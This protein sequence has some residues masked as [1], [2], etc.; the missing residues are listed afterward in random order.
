MRYTV[1]LAELG[2]AIDHVAR[3]MVARRGAA[4]RQL[5]R[6][7]AALP[8]GHTTGMLPDLAARWRARERQVEEGLAGHAEGLRAAA[9]IYAEA[10]SDAAATLDRPR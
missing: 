10:E 5:D 2:R 7:A 3:A 1:D 9:E 4:S 8:R 6:V